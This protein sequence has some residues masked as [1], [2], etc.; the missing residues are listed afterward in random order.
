MSPTSPISDR[1]LAD[2]V[3]F[4]TPNVKCRSGFSPLPRARYNAGVLTYLA[5]KRIRRS[6][7]AVDGFTRPVDCVLAYNE[8][9]TVIPAVC[10]EIREYD[11]RNLL[12]HIL[13]R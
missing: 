10:F 13:G 4:E 1:L 8:H 7:S 6:K 2:V 5:L 12:A 3:V 9:L 11:P